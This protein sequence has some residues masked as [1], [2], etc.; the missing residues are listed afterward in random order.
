MHT[1]VIQ[2]DNIVLDGSGY[3][4]EGNKSWMGLAPRWGDAGNNGII[5]TGQNHVNI[6]NL[7]IEGFTAGVRISGSSNINIVGNRFTEEAAV[8]DTPMGI[9][10]EASS[11]V[12]IENNNF[13]RINGP[14][15]ACNG[16]NITIR[17]NTLTEISDGIDGSIALQGSSNTITDNK[18]IT[19]SPSIR[20]GSANSNIIARNH[21]TGSIAFVSSSNNQIFQN[22]LTGIRLIFS[23]NNTFFGNVMANNLVYDTIALDQGAV[24]NTFYANTFPANCSVRINDLGTTFWDNGTIGNYWGD[25][26]G[27]DRN[28]D[29]IGDSS[30]IITAVKWDNS[31]RG[32]ISFVAGQDN[33]PLIASYDVENDGVAL[34]SQTETFV[35][36]LVAIVAA[37]ALCVGLLVHFK[38][39]RLK[40]GGKP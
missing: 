20:L 36:V 28:G 24:N 31:I 9:V 4:I 37:V 34:P 1:I 3:L 22:N 11:H 14:A 15:I 33:Y 29:G 39:R 21:I 17:R 23:A 13:T 16:T 6:T 5:I 26:R 27:T 12:L 18:I 2:R 25:Y 35:V 38:K 10:T 32:D 7:N 8:F 40:S 19:A 30:Y